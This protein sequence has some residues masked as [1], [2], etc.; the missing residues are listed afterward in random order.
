MDHSVT[1]GTSIQWTDVH[2]S[3][4]L[5]TAVSNEWQFLRTIDAYGSKFYEPEFLS[6]AIRR[7]EQCW[8]PIFVSFMVFQVYSPYDSGL[9]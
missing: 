9:L 7:Y 1:W 6:N 4:N 3:V 8:L 2:C 5:V